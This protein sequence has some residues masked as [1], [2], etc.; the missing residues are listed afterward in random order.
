MK[1][2]YIRDARNNETRL[3][4]QKERL[5]KFNLD[6]LII[7]PNGKDFGEGFRALLENLKPGDELHVVHVGRITR[8]KYK[9]LEVL[10]I[11]IEK[12]IVLYEA[13]NIV[14]KKHLQMFLLVES[15]SRGG[16]SYDIECDEDE[17]DEI[18]KVY[19][20]MKHWKSK[21]YSNIEAVYSTLEKAERGKKEH[22]NDVDWNKSKD[23][24]FEITEH[25]VNKE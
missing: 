18:K 2:G 10:N 15:Y 9:F 25:D 7:E 13:D 17:E 20:L 3:Q 6:K 11:L 12:D 19:V 16:I 1:Y 8:S 4:E 22:E 24:Y 5:H 21:D 23:Y 14:D